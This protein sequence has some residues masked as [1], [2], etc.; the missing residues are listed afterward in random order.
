MKRI[1]VPVF[2]LISVSTL[3]LLYQWTSSQVSGGEGSNHDRTLDISMMVKEETLTFDFTYENLDPGIYHISLPVNGEHLSCLNEDEQV[4]RILHKEENQMNVEQRARITLQYEIP[5]PDKGILDS[6]KLSLKKKDGDGIQTPFSLSV[7]DYQPDDEKWAAP[8]DK[9]SDYQL[10]NV[11]Y[12]QF[13]QTTGHPPLLLHQKGIWEVEGSIVSFDKE[14]PVGENV[15]KDLKDLLSETGPMIVQLDQAV[16]SIAERYMTIKGRDINALEAEY[17]AYHIGKIAKTEDPW[18]AN[19]VKDIFGEGNGPMASEILAALSGEELHKWKKM[20]LQKEANVQAGRFLDLSLASI[21]GM[22][23]DFFEG[24]QS[25]EERLLYFKYPGQASF[26]GE[27]I[28]SP[29][30]SKRRSLYFPLEEVASLAGYELIEIERNQIYR[31]E[32]PSKTYRFYADHQN[33]HFE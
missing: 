26:E 10:E 5:L 28:Q 1:W 21:Y 20:I 16:T 4:C 17:L 33:F 22:P 2:L 11:H 32:M 14:T 23:T 29:V 30:L 15:K 12:Q 8:I 7:K 6:W 31:L 18:E 3:L 19:V 24:G 9:V 25:G 13:A 27:P